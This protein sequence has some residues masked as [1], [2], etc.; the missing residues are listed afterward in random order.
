MRGVYHFCSAWPK[1]AAFR[2]LFQWAEEEED[3]DDDKDEEDRAAKTVLERGR[4]CIKEILPMQ[5]GHTTKLALLF[6][7]ISKTMSERAPHA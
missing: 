1:S 7:H 4:W 6:R 3:D 2:R 5:H